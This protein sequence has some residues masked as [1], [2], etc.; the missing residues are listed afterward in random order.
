MSKTIICDIETNGLEDVTD[1]WVACT[2]ELETGETHAYRGNNPEDIKAFNS[3]VSTATRVV[4]HNF[5][6]YD[7]KWLSALW[8]TRFKKDQVFDTL[9]LS[10]LLFQDRRKLHSL[11]AWGEELCDQKEH[12]EDWSHWSQEMEDYCHQDVHVTE[13]LYR[14]LLRKVMSY[15]VPEST[16][17]LE[18]R[19]QKLLEDMAEYGAPIDTDLCRDYLKD[20]EIEVLGI[21]DRMQQEIAPIWKPTNDVRA[22]RYKKDGTLT[23][24]SQ[25]LLKGT[26]TKRAVPT[27]NKDEYL[28]EQL[29]LFNPK[30][31]T[32]IP[33]FL[34][35]HWDPVSFTKSGL[36]KADEINL[37]T[38]HEDAPD[39][40]KLIPRYV[41]IKSRIS[42]LKGFLEATGQDNRVHGTFKSIGAAS[43]RMAHINPNMANI[44]SKG[45][46][47]KE[48]RSL[49]KV[50]E[51]YS[52]VGC[53]A[54]GIQLRAYAHYTRD[55]E[56][57][58]SILSADPHVH[59]AKIYGYLKEEEEYNEDNP[60]HVKARNLSKKTTY[61]ILM[62]G[63]GTRIASYFGGTRAE[64]QKVINRFFGGI[65]G[66]ARVKK[67]LALCGKRKYL[68]GL[69]GSPVSCPSAHKGMSYLL[70][71][72][73]AAIIKYTMCMADSLIKKKG[74]PARQYAVVHDEIQYQVKQGYEDEVGQLVASCFREAGKFYQTRIPMD[75]DYK[76]GPSWYDS[77]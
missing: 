13:T 25:R 37:E 21:L 26:N 27:G 70:Q 15:K 8:G 47:G 54:K 76:F 17:I 75:G 30:S 50:P 32:T 67:Y 2:K 63:S 43:H 16:V 41:T 36:A 65:S 35:G 46:Y 23:V 39:S 66:S 14:Y 38:L 6:C 42:V 20:W 77:H 1:I 49:I 51:G 71:S 4:G 28:V 57:I 29:I 19:S 10:R 48:T 68:I 59:L 62:G 58:E 11:R 12:Y 18:M 74:L 52:S 72:F 44:P 61:T 34:E 24:A 5:I 60:D 73:E 64:G 69:D 31:P 56:L 3:L 7:S 55:Q 45:L 53:D 9:M 40:L 22:L 33:L